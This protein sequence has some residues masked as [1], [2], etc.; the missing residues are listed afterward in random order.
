MKIRRLIPT[1]FIAGLFACV[2]SGAKAGPGTTSE[3]E[4]DK[5]RGLP[6]ERPMDPILEAESP[7]LQP[8]GDIYRVDI[9]SHSPQLGAKH[10]ALVTIVAFS[11]F[12]CPFCAKVAPTLKQVLEAYPGQVRVVFRHNP[13]AFHKDAMPAA[14]AS[15]AA[16]RQGRFWEMHDKLFSDR[17]K[18]DEDSV[19]GQASALG[20]DM[21][22]F[23]A[24]F[25]SAEVEQQI[26]YD[27][28]EAKRIGAS[29]VPG[30]YINGHRFSGAQPFERF[31]AKIDELMPLARQAGGVGDALYVRLTRCGS[32]QK[33]PTAKQPPA[34]RPPRPREDPDKI[35]EVPAGDSYWVG[36]QTARVQI[37]IF[38]DFQCPYCSRIGKTMGK[39]LDSYPNDVRI[40]FKHHPL[41][42]HKD[43]FLAHQASLA[44]G[45]QGQFWQMHDLLFA[46]SRKL[47]RADLEEYA[48]QVGL[49]M[50]RFRSD[51]DQN[52]YRAVIE[53]DMALA[54]QLGARG[55]PTAFVN[56]KKLVG[57]QPFDKFKETIERALGR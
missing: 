41:P 47:K 30:F 20:L 37:V 35:Y 12:Q 46:N 6:A 5:P 55:T 11:E 42:F 10:E 19:F 32:I 1:L 51:L 28:D 14:K 2:A 21:Q 40:I 8:A 13:L 43:A 31:K 29:G 18:L 17:K 25:R 26:R 54:K 45:A 23:A 4:G 56:G 50:H 38:S 36:S 53:A 48:Q 9:P 39:V 49:D 34:E 15:M 27:M 16:H 3:T 33:I 52:A 44:A 24:D 7:C 22:R 57:A